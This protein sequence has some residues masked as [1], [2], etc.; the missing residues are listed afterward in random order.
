MSRMIMIPAPA[1]TVAS[2]A[3]SHHGSPPELGSASAAEAESV[4]GRVTLGRG[5]VV[6]ER[7][8]GCRSVKW[9]TPPT[10]PW[11]EI[12]RY[13][14]AYWPAAVSGATAAVMT[15]PLVVGVPSWYC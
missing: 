5:D 2:V 10:A 12:T 3:H 1:V 14:T 15:S 9:T 11:A 6:P 7:A 4:G 8:A 13:A